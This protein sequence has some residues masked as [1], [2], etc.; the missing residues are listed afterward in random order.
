MFIKNII[1]N[2]NNSEI[3]IKKNKYKVQINYGKV[4]YPKQAKNYNQIITK[5]KDN[6]EQDKEDFKFP[7]PPDA[8]KINKKG[9]YIDDIKKTSTQYYLIAKN[10]TIEIIRQD[11]LADRSL[12]ISAG[13]NDNFELF[14]IIEGEVTYNND[15]ILHPGDSITV[16][17]GEKEIYL[18]T[19]TDTTLLYLTSSPIFAS[20]QKRIQKLFELNNNV[21]KQ[22]VET[23][24]HCNRLQNLSRITGAELGLNEK[25]LYN[26]G[27]ASFL[28]DV[29]KANVPVE[30]L[31]KPD[32]LNK[33]EWNIMKNH[34]IWGKELVFEYFNKNQF[35]KIGEIINQ[36]HERYDGSGY[37]NGIKGNNILIEA[38]ILSVV[39]AFDAMTSERPYQK[40]IS[41]EKAI[42]EI[43]SQKGKQFSPKV[44]EA[45]INAIQKYDIK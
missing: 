36:H 43:K 19:L 34:T 14:Y 38:Q 23:K 20:Y 18:K 7:K 37:P 45:F 5:L 4:N 3:S 41:K 32:K 12:Q 2:L 10:K 44:V 9:E 21:A 35:K 15:K 22:D 13:E 39:D 29:G 27:F 31:Q 6:L 1:K 40:A 42:E 28:H 11:I 16:R 25:K 17:S 30:I 33:E 8:I 26:L 24:E